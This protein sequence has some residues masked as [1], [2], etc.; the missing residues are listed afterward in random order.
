M[1]NPV[2]SGAPAYTPAAQAKTQTQQTSASQT[3]GS[4]NTE[5]TVELSSQAKSALSGGS[6]TKNGQ[7]YSKPLTLQAHS[8]RGAAASH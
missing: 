3:S 1:I 4:S 8:S 6:T 2:S 5:D 7:D